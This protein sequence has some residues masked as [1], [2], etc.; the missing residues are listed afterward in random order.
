M[1]NIMTLAEVTSE[2][3]QL[4]EILEHTGGGGFSVLHRAD[5][6]L[7]DL[8]A[9]LVQALRYIVRELDSGREVTIS[10]STEVLTSQQAADLLGMSRPTLVR[11]LDSGHLPFEKIGSHRRVLRRDVLAFRERRRQ[12]QYAALDAM[13][14][15]DD[16]DMP[17]V[18][19][20][21]HTRKEA[22]DNRRES[23]PR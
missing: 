18:R 11:L 3:P 1:S 14:F 23:R 13:P 7:A 21:G 19:E 20:M 15:Y 6:L 4:R 10:S 8:P 9:E 16:D 12:E 5:G 22:G 17:D 2:S